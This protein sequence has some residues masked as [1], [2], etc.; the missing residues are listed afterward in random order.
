MI[1]GSVSAVRKEQ[2]VPMHRGV[3]CFGAERLTKVLNPYAAYAPCRLRAKTGFLC[4][5]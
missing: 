1:T 5:L 2:R 3:I 4:R